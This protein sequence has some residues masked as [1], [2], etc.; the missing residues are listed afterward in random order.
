MAVSVAVTVSVA[1]AVTVTASVAASA[2][3]AAAVAIW[4][5]DIARHFVAG[6]AG[7]CESVGQRTIL[8]ICSLNLFCT[9]DLR[10]VCI[11]CATACTQS[12]EVPYTLYSAPCAST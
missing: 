10:P 6:M 5:Y 3:V 9:S 8:H 7:R 1:V 11:G 12:V 4:L 2:S